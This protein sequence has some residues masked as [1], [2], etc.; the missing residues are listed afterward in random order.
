L[1]KDRPTKEK[2]GKKVPDFADKEI[3]KSVPQRDP[4]W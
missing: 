4:L 2:N 3:G 1:K